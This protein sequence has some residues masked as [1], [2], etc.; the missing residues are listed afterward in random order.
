MA[1]TGRLQV[2]SAGQF[3]DSDGTVHSKNFKTTTAAITRGQVC[4]F[5][6]GTTARTA[7]ATD[8]PPVFVANTS[9]LLNDLHCD[10]MWG[11]DVIFYVTASGAINPYADVECAAAGAV[12]AASANAVIGKY[13]KHGTKTVDGVTDLPAAAN[14]E[15]IGIKLLNRMQ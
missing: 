1:L 9:K 13:V 7:V 2:H 8:L 11:D 4:T 14:G 6:A 12:A 15:V 5:D 3:D 10:L